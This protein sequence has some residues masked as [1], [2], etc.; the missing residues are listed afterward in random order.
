[1]FRARRPVRR[2]MTRGSR[3][4]WVMLVP[5][6]RT[7]NCFAVR[8]AT[9]PLILQSQ[10]S[11]RVK[12]SGCRASD[13]ST[14]TARTIAPRSPHGTEDHRRLRSRTRNESVICFPSELEVDELAPA[15]LARQHEGVE[16]GRVE[17]AADVP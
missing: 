1:M 4:C 11:G 10:H 12:E 3:L 8:L 2:L 16:A 7:S 17:D 6:Q 14:A 9:W 15:E 5:R 13:C